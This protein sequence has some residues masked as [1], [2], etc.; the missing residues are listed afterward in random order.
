MALIFSLG[1]VVEPAE[2]YPQFF[3]NNYLN[4]YNLHSIRKLAK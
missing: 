1:M 4:I 2:T 3:E